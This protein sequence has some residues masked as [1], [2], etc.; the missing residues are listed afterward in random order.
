MLWPSEPPY[1][2]IG[3]PFGFFRPAN[4]DLRH[5]RVQATISYRSGIN[6]EFYRRCQMAHPLY[7]YLLSPLDIG[8]TELKNRIVMG[9]M[10]TG[11]EEDGHFRRL[12]HYYAVRARGGW[13]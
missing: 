8:F 13:V 1:Q 4:R 11:F 6:T 9:S 2:H 7:P 10:H 5:M 3:P 12:A